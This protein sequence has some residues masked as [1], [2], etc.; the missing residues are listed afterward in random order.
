MSKW[1]SCRRN[2]AVRDFVSQKPHPLF[3]IPAVGQSLLQS[4]STI[5]I[6]PTRNFDFGL[7]GPFPHVQKIDL[8]D[9]ILLKSLSAFTNLASILGVQSW[10]EWLYSVLKS[11]SISSAK[12]FEAHKFLLSNWWLSSPK[13][14]S[15]TTFQFWTQSNWKPRFC[16]IALLFL[17]SSERTFW[18]HLSGISFVQ[19]WLYLPQSSY[20]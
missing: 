15:D 7:H 19:F 17:G 3:N 20:S 6:Q 9:K 11:N 10:H 2:Q 8:K 14:F 18:W 1:I 5:H 12:I 13:A 4:L 16:L